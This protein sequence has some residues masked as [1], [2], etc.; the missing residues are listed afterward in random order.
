MKIIVAIPVY[1]EEKNIQSLIRRLVQ[2]LQFCLID[3]E[4]IIYLDGCTDHSVRRV[5]EECKRY[6]FITSYVSKERKGKL[7]ALNFLSHKIF[8]FKGVDYVL[9]VDSDICFDLQIIRQSIEVIAER[10]ALLAVKVLPQPPDQPNIFYRWA[11][12]CCR[13]YDELRNRAST[14]NRLWFVS[15]NFLLFNIDVY[16]SVFP[17]QEVKLPNEDAYIGWYLINNG[18]SVVYDS[19][20]SIQTNFPKN[21]KC[22]LRQKIRVRNGFV[23]LKRENAPVKQLRR[24]LNSKAIKQI[25]ISGQYD[26]L[27]LLILDNFIY[28]LMCLNITRK[29]YHQSWERIS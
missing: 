9:L 19:N 25:F 11:L 4:I 16:H 27:F 5:E 15:G 26:L 23:Q 28:N 2:S 3:Y 20:I 10:K 1:N 29:L 7:F 14:E 8:S 18:I 12:L 6:Q 21:L 24:D 22:F 17:I 13:V